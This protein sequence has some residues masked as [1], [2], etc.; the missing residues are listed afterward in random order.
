MDRGVFAHELD[1]FFC[2]ELPR[3]VEHGRRMFDDLADSF[4]RWLVIYGA[5]SL[6]RKTAAG[7]RSLGAPPL[8]LADNNQALWGCQ[9]E[10]IPVVPPGEIV[11]RFGSKVVVV[12]AVWS[13]GP[14]RRLPVI[15]GQ[16][17]SMGCARAIPF[18][19]LF[20]KYPSTFLPHYRLD[21]PQYLQQAEAPIRRVFAL[22]QDDQ[23]RR[24][25]INQLRW[26]AAT[27]FG[28][29]SGRDV[30]ETYLPDDV[31]R[32]SSDEVLVDC[33]AF[34][35]DTI[36]AFLDHRAKVFDRIFAFEPDPTN[37]LRLESYVA[38]LPAAIAGRIRVFRSAVSDRREVLRFD[39]SGTVSS[40][41]SGAG[42]LDVPCEPID[43]ALAGEAVTYVKMDIEGA[44]PK[45][46]QGARQTIAQHAPALAIC[47]Y[48][49]QQHL[50]ELPLQMHA[51]C[52]DYRLFLRH[53]GD[54][55]GDVVCYAV[56]PR[57]RDGKILV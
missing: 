3:I 22:L 34:D 10:G 19:V 38:G 44:E 16:L 24:E 50:W 29:L 39:A 9:V 56:P 57:H 6:G 36:R 52:R 11:R 14:E 35:G 20:W 45:A 21:L 42:A 27:E 7:L 31:L 28:A 47:V 53:Y 43:E 13:P 12:M 37:Y 51:L 55:F 15:R 1:V 48:H 41:I 32:L 23:S 33:G 18:T 40:R 17:E 26:I 4:S 8:A 25:Y 2:K 30:R 5:G 49:R 46:L 54:E